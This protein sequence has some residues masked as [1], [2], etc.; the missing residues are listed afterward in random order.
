ME[1]KQREAILAKLTLQE[2][3]TPERWDV[4]TSWVQESR[5]TCTHAASEYEDWFR[6][7]GDPN[8]EVRANHVWKAM[9]ILAPGP[10]RC[11]ARIPA[12]QELKELPSPI[13][14][15][16]PLD[17]PRLLTGLPEEPSADQKL[18]YSRFYGAYRGELSRFWEEVPE[19]DFDG[20][21]SEG[22]AFAS[23]L[24][25]LATLERESEPFVHSKTGRMQMFFH[26]ADFDVVE[27]WFQ[28]SDHELVPFETVLERL[29]VYVV[30][31]PDGSPGSNVHLLS[32]GYL[33]EQAVNGLPHFVVVRPDERSVWAGR[34][35][36]PI[37]DVIVHTDQGEARIP[38]PSPGVH[39]LR[40]AP[41]EEE[42]EEDWDSEEEPFDEYEE[43]FRHLPRY[44]CDVA[45]PLFV[46]LKDTP[47]IDELLAEYPDLE[48]LS[49]QGT[50][51]RADATEDEKLSLPPSFHA[52]KNLRSLSLSRVCLASPLDLSA[53]PKLEALS[54]HGMGLKDLDL[55]CLSDDAS[56]LTLDVRGNDLLALPKGLMRHTRLISLELGGNPLTEGV[57]G[58]SALQD[59]RELQFYDCGFTAFPSVVLELP[60]L[61]RLNLSCNL[62]FEL[63]PEIGQ[64]T[65]L[66]F[67]D[68]G[69]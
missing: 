24:G 7:Q 42:P 30:Q 56:L 68:L 44:R 69:S 31:E 28:A 50:G 58:L 14:F 51:Y 54:L 41:R 19:P 13:M 67:L 21:V 20:N 18:L 59:L 52:L 16:R 26:T 34:R 48:A 37:E 4:F 27:S 49:I 45:R 36:Q 43:N 2:L 9:E 40:V 25:K 46:N 61:E 1:N 66:R 62:L 10:C 3:I 57:D 29:A 17:L 63:G 47:L 22:M 23:A 38:E 11:K 8:P 65:Q 60:A 12:S 6:D 32:D 33:Q 15:A 55:T 64:L 35:W 53:F 39:A 5:D